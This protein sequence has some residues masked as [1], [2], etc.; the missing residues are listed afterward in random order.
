M[1]FSYNNK[2]DHCA[3][4]ER[5]FILQLEIFLIFSRNTNPFT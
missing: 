5:E 2:D 3:E 4:N 1:Y